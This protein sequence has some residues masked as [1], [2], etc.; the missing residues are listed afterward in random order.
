MTLQLP[1]PPPA[2]ATEASRAGESL[3][4]PAAFFYTWLTR[5]LRYNNRAAHST[6][7]FL[8]GL[9]MRTR[10]CVSLV[11]AN[12]AATLRA[13]KADRTHFSHYCATHE[14]TPVSAAPATV[15]A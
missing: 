8:D 4:I 1:K 12:A 7:H 2:R 15:G 10:R 6:P 5:R 9:L 3:R 11:L 14:F 13:Y